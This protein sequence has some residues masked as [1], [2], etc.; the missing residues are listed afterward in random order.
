[1]KIIP[2]KFSLAKAIYNLYHKTNIAPIGHKKSYV[3]LEGNDWNY[4]GLTEELFDDLYEQEENEN[5]IHRQCEL[6]IC[7]DGSYKVIDGGRFSAWVTFTRGKVIGICS[8]GNTIARFKDKNIFEITRICFPSYFKPKNNKEKKYPSKFIRESIK[9]FKK[10]YKVSKL[11]TYIHNWQSGK[12]LEYAG[13]KKDKLII[14]SNNFKGWS[15]RPNR[16]KPD[17]KPKIRFVV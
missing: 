8:I 16:N 13:F 3:A 6:D 15:N 5:I 7:K 11:V 1:M 14:Y 9:D 12:Y 17:L 4:L 2:I 10:N